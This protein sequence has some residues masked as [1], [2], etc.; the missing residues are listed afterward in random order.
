LQARIS[1]AHL[2]RDRR[3]AGILIAKV[4]A[5]H[6]EKPSP[7]MSPVFTKWLGLANSNIDFC[8]HD[9]GGRCITRV[10]CP[11]NLNDDRHAEQN[12]K[13]RPVLDHRSIHLG[14]RFIGI[15][16]SL[17]FRRASRVGSRRYDFDCFVVARRSG[18][19]T[20]CADQD[21]APLFDARPL[22][23]LGKVAK[24]FGPF[25]RP[26]TSDT[27]ERA[28]DSISGFSKNTVLIETTGG[29]LRLPC[30]LRPQGFETVPDR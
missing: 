29:R 27:S 13:R 9:A 1:K 8:I 19:P 14:R 23:R 10:A 22:R 6:N 5:S 7:P 28:A 30:D 18:A 2:Y 17:S 4:G 3:T 11:R 20:E 25:G 21:R 16:G 26:V 15:V 24:S 12:Q